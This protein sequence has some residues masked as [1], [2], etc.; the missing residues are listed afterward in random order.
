MNDW[1]KTYFKYFYGGK[2]DMK[3]LPCTDFSKSGKPMADICPAV[4]KLDKLKKLDPHLYNQLNHIQ[5]D[6]NNCQVIGCRLCG[7]E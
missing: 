5:H 4:K 7:V 6:P 2:P 1:L 3:D